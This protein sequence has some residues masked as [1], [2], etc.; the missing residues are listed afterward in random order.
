M[1]NR[2][3]TGTQPANKVLLGE[4]LPLIDAL[5]IIDSQYPWY[6]RCGPSCTGVLSVVSHLGKQTFMPNRHEIRREAVITYIARLESRVERQIP[7]LVFI[8]L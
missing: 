6:L 1:G 5:P 8:W 3:F 4:H 7:L 2:R